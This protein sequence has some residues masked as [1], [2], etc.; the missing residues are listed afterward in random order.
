MLPAAATL[1]SCSDTDAVALSGA[2]MA[3]AGGVALNIVTVVVALLVWPIVSATVSVSVQLLEFTGM[4]PSPTGIVG[5]RPLN[6][7][8]VD[9]GHTSVQV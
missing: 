5:V 7:C 3:A 4:P 9:S 1:R 2:V 6:V 8:S